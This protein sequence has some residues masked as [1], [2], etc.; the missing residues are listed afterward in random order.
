MEPLTTSLDVTFDGKMPCAVPICL[1]V[2]R[3]TITHL[4]YIQLRV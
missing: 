4:G 1:T 2:L 3:F